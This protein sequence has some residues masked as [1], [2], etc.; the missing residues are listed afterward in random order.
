[1]MFISWKIVH[2]PVLKQG[3][4]KRIIIVNIQAFGNS[5]GEEGDVERTVFSG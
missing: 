3:Y 5:L 1:M 4:W 2:I